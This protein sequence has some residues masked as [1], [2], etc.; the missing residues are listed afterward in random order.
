MRLSSF[1]IFRISFAL[2]A[3]SSTAALAIYGNSFSGFCQPENEVNNGVIGVP[4][5]G[6]MEHFVPEGSACYLKKRVF[7]Y[8]FIF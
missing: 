5:N 3:W 8:R 6:P 7:F 4:P 2:Q 1:F